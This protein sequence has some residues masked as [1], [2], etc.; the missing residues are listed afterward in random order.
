MPDTEVRA[1][2]APAHRVFITG[3]YGAL[4]TAV[5]EAFVRAVTGYTRESWAG[6]GKRGQCQLIRDR[7]H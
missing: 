5:S 7:E 2:A 6:P 1:E 3:A 4:G